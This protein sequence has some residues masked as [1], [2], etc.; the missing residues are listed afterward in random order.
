MADEEPVIAPDQLKEGHAKAFRIAGVLVAIAL[1]LMVF[2]NHGH[3]EDIWLLCIA[4]GII[5]VIIGD[6]VLRRKGLKR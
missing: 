4:V 6:G 1:A 5:A 3:V 2:N